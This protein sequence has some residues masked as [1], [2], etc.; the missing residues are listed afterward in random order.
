MIPI[1]GLVGNVVVVEAMAVSNC[2]W[3]L[4]ALLVVGG[5]NRFVF[6]SVVVRYES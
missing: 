5:V 1:N 6:P 3:G 4:G 2:G